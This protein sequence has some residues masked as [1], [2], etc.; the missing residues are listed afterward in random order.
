M[1]SF[2]VSKIRRDFPFLRKKTRKG[3]TPVYLDSAATTQKPFQVINAMR[4]YYENKNANPHRGVYELSEIATEEYEK[5]RRKTAE[6][7]NSETEEIIFT[8]NTTEAINLVKNSFAAEFLKSGDRILISGMEH[9]AN[10]V[11]W[12]M[13]KQN[14]IELD[15]IEITAEGELEENWE[16]RITPKTKIV[17]VTHASTVLGTINNVREICKTAREK[18]CITVVDGAQAAPHFKVDVKKIGCDFY[19]F[20]GHKMLAP[21]GIGVLYGEKELLEKMPPFLGGGD[22][23]RSVERQKAECNDIPYKFEAGTPNVEGAVGLSSAIDY[24]NKLVFEN[25]RNHEEKLTRKAL[26]ELSSFGKIRVLGPLNA[27]ERIG[28]IAFTHS[29]IHPHD[30]ASVMDSHSIAIR[31]GHHCAM[32]LHKTFGIQ[33][34]ARASFY[35][36]NNAAEIDAFVEALEDAEKIF[37][38]K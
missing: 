9:H 11:P 8:R 27:K 13:L 36:Y 26:G 34:S 1:A 16:E 5:A 3:K 37:G 29:K 6:F 24:L 25:I 38:A 12:I 23:I 18:G 28:A 22:M 30:V 35:V 14:G 4:D 32:P 20:S 31:S 21:M 2:D 17:C 19:A 7:V 15:Y 33:A 10:I